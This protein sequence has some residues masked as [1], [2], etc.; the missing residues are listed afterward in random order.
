[1][2]NQSVEMR[3]WELENREEEAKTG[4]VHLPPKEREQKIR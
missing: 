1:M 2:L 4:R 3:G